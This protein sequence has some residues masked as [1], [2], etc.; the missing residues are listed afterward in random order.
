MNRLRGAELRPLMRASGWASS[1]AIGL[2]V[3]MIAAAIGTASW[4]ANPWTSIAAIIF[5]GARQHAPAAFWSRG[6]STRW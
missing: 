1:A 4:M 6:A 5:V 3:V 2:E